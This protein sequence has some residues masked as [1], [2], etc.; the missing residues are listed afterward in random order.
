MRGRYVWSKFFFSAILGITGLWL[1]P[2]GEQKNTNIATTQFGQNSLLKEPITIPQVIELPTLNTSIPQEM[3]GSI[4]GE[5]TVS[6]VPEETIPVYPDI[7]DSKATQ[8]NSS[9]KQHL[10]EE[11]ITKKVNKTNPELSLEVERLIKA[12]QIFLKEMEKF[13]PNKK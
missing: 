11:E 4:K 12:N 9:T 7:E 10:K 6:F 13:A 8:N 5:G 3:H 2:N 1:L